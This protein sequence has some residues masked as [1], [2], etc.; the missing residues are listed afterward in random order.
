MKSAQ[1]AN[2][3][4]LAVIEVGYKFG[5]GSTVAMMPLWQAAEVERVRIG[6]VQNERS[7]AIRKL[8]ELIGHYNKVDPTN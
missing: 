1:A 7:Q 6:E 8:A 3:Q 5:Q 2:A 4:R